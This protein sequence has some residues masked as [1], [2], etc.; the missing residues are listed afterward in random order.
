[1]AHKAI[2]QAMLPREIAAWTGQAGATILKD[3]GR[4]AK[5]PRDP[6][7]T[8]RAIQNIRSPALLLR[9]EDL[10]IGTK[11]MPVPATIPAPRVDRRPVALARSPV[12]IKPKDL[13][14]LPLPEVQDLAKV[15]S[16]HA[17]LRREVRRLPDAPVI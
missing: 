13:R 1:M 12:L 14:H 2:A 7:P 3:R 16:I 17:L 5:V 4:T 10:I 6:G 9:E 11:R 15:A 8:N